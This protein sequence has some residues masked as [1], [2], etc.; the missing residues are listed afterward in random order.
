MRRK[1]ALWIVVSGILFSIILAGCNGE[2][3]SDS[4]GSG[5]E[6]QTEE[7][8]LNEEVQN[9]GEIIE[10]GSL[11]YGLVSDSPFEGILNSAFL[12]AAP[13]G[14]VVQFF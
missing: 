3:E 13:D 6:G 9:D 2:G 10:D 11:T 8:D 4:E 12:A 7:I 1:S 5:A 14:Q